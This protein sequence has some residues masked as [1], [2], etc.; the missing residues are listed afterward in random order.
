[1]ENRMEHL[2][3][4]K[5]YQGE[6][7]WIVEEQIFDDRYLG[8]CEAIFT[9][10]NGYLGVRNALEE[11][12][13]GEQ[14]GMF[15][16]G[17]FN[18][19]IPSEVPELPNFPDVTV[20][21]IFINGYRFHLERGSFTDYCRSMNYKT[22]ESRRS[23]LWSCPD[24][25]KVKLCFSRFVSLCR[26]HI[27]CGKI[28]ITPVDGTAAVSVES[29]LDARITN[30][31]V[32]H[33]NT[34]DSRILDGKYM[35]TAVTT[36]ESG[37]TGVLHVTNRAFVNGS[38]VEEKP[39][40]YIRN[41]RNIVTYNIGLA[42]G[43]T[44]CI[45]KLS[46]VY[47]TRDLAYVGITEE[48]AS[49]KVRED[50]LEEVK[51]AEK[52]GYDALFEESRAAWL[53]FWEKHDVKIDTENV[54]DKVAVRFAVYHLHIMN[55]P[56][57]NRLGVGA[58]G[59]SGEEYKGHSFWDTEIF[60]MP[61][62]LFSQPEAAKSLLE[63]RYYILEGAR[64]K[65]QKQG[66]KGGM[67]PWEAAWITDDEVCADIIGV[68]VET[69][70]PM[71]VL[72]G[73]IEVHIS[74]DIA[75]A[76]MEYYAATKDEDF[77]QRCGYEM[78]LETARFWA[79]R[80][81][82]RG[83]RYEILNVIGPDEYKEEV[84][85]DVYTNY[86]AHYNMK[87]ALECLEKMKEADYTRLDKKLDLTKLRAEV[88]EVLPKLYLPAPGENGVVPQNDTYLG[89]REIDLEKY[90]NSEVAG[91]IHHD[92]SMER[93]KEIQA[94][95]Q[96]DIVVLMY[97]LDGLFSEKIK[98]ENYLYYEARTTHDSSLSKCTHSILANDMGMKE[99]AYRFFEG[100][101]GTDVG[102]NLKSCN[103]G[104]HS[105][106]CGGIWQCAV[107]GFGGVRIVD[108]ELRI[109]PKLPAAWNSMEFA[110]NWRGERLKVKIHADKAEIIREEVQKDV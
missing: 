54:L 38:P 40:P 89:L 9:Q 72:C 80:A 13:V 109:E 83:G 12:Y 97:L 73:E 56:D 48:E 69:G 36:G 31:G 103:N 47:T 30:T 35:E 51:L 100:A 84:D 32:Q 65:A 61:Y 55:K 76:V 3:Y 64:R 77:M 49:K 24:G 15:I 82:K 104:I 39:M 6:T 74:A 27:I 52:Q 86:M 5:Q 88:E 34:P 42:A 29:G 79:S 66:Y 110:L 43:S 92:Y 23:L 85:N 22:G 46:S 96:G 102:S 16:N 71:R 106:A 20:S 60:L 45:E 63:Y 98:K 44:L 10:G 107:M 62:Y 108:G 50:G 101:A 75:Y 95:K 81:V 4:Q 41:R 18:R 28:E 93:L 7:G 37:I 105:A 53:T 99:E 33:F 17:T 57:D 78:L 1:M 90:K 87:I 19:P 8:K 21:D 59:L 58:K 91:T 26:E 94:S 2:N 11:R 67:Y 68:D 70:K 14:R 25:T